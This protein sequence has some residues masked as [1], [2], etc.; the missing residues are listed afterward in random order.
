MLRHSL[1]L[2]WR[3]LLKIKHSPEQLLDLSLTPIMFVTLFVFLF[4]TAA[5]F[6]RRP[7]GCE[8]PAAVAYRP[9]GRRGKVHMRQTIGAPR[10][11]QLAVR[12]GGKHLVD[13]TAAHERG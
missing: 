1:T 13:A 12:R 5:G 2:A 9:V 3:A 10:Q 6:T 11:S 4:G 8:T 7:G